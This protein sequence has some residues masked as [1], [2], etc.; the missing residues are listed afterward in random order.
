MS[1]PDIH[2]FEQRSDVTSVRVC[3]C[4]KWP[5]HHVHTGARALCACDECLGEVNPHLA[6]EEFTK[7]AEELDR[8]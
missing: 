4:G 6:D 7:L 8:P 2:P 5:D 3:H 1:S